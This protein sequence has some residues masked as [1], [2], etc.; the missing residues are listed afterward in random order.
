MGD[1][2]GR[3][4]LVTGGASGMGAGLVTALPRLGARVVSLDRA[5]DPGRAVAAAAGAEFVTADVTDQAAVIAAVDR[6]VDLLD[7]LDVLIHAAGV[8]PSGPAGAMS[9]DLWNEVMA[10]NAT[11]TFL[12]NQAV[13]RHLSDA[14]GSIL[15]FA[16]AAGLVGYPGKAAYAAA[17]G[18]VIAWTRSIAREWAPY[19]IRVNGIAPAIVTPMY[20]RTR[21]EMSPEQL[22]EHDQTMRNSVPLGGSLGDIDR[23]LVPA[24]A[25][26]ISDDS[27]F[28]TGQ[29]LPVDGGIV[30]MR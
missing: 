4:I 16:S 14:G 5:A 28:I 10:I 3:R 12:T 13:F 18:A 20:A 8:A 1:L 22:V 23:D 15:N 24:V 19:G 17:K 7:G 27:R 2:R 30:A 11:G 9:A 21:A 26:L 29:I 25:F 6:A